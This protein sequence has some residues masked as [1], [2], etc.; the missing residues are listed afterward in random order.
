MQKLKSGGKR[1]ISWHKY[2]PK[3][4]TL[5][6]PNPYLDY[7]IEPSFQ[8]VNRLFVLPFNTL[9]NR[10]EHSRYYLPTAKV[11]DYNVMIAG[12]N[13]FDQ[14]IKND[15]KTYENIQNYFK[16]YYKMTP[17]DLTKQQALAFD[18]KPT[19]KITFTENLDV[20]DI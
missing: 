20:N 10:T 16:Q 11:E 12:R 3:T 18:P 15:V 17:I 9:D 8:G 7:L 6:A 5:T 13:F 19:Q 1:T 2:H 14:P 4:K